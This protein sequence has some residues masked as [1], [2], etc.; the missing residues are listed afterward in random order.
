MRHGIWFCTLFSMYLNIDISF[1]IGRNKYF[2]IIAAATAV[3][4]G[5]ETYLLLWWRFINNTMGGVL[6]VWL[7]CRHTRR[8]CRRANNSGD[9]NLKCWYTYMRSIYLRTNDLR[10]YNLHKYKMCTTSGTTAKTHCNR[11]TTIDRHS[12][13]IRTCQS[14]KYI[15]TIRFLNCYS[16]W[17]FYSLLKLLLRVSIGI[18]WMEN[19]DWR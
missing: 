9:S 15:Y 19:I 13:A 12:N 16:F 1:S 10:F 6:C 7:S 3:G 11:M 17:F 2:F 18:R 14:M 8:R 4:I 5:I